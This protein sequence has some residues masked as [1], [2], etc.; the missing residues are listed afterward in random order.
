MNIKTK[1]M[2]GILVVPFIL[3]MA[4]VLIV[5]AILNLTT[6]FL[7]LIGFMDALNFLLKAL[8]AAIKKYEFNKHLSKMDKDILKSED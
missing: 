1:I 6:K 8:L 5:V 3:V 7:I 4:A 2:V